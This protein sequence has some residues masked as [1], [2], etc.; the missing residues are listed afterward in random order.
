MPVITLD[1]DRLDRNS[2]SAAHGFAFN[3]TMCD[4]VQWAG[5]GQPCLQ[6]SDGW[7]VNGDVRDLK[8]FGMMVA[9]NASEAPSSVATLA[10]E[11]D[12]AILTPNATSLPGTIASAA[13]TFGTAFTFTTL[14]A[15]ASCTYLNDQCIQNRSPAGAIIITC[16][17]AGWPELPLNTTADDDATSI[18]Q[19]GAGGTSD[20]RIFSVR[21]NSIGYLSSTYDRSIQ[22][23]PNYTWSA[24]PGTIGIQLSMPLTGA[25]K[26][27]NANGQVLADPKGFTFFGC[28]LEYFNVTTSYN[29]I[30]SSY[31]L[32]TATP[33]TPYFA[34]VLLGPLITQLAN[35][36]LLADAQSAILIG[37]NIALNAIVSQDLGRMAIA[38]PSGMFIEVPAAGTSRVD[39]QALGAYP[40]APVI[41]ITILLYLYAVLALSVFLTSRTFTSYNIKVIRTDSDD[42]EQKMAAVALGQKWLTNAIPLVSMAFPEKDG[43][44]GQRSV[45]PRSVEMVDDVDEDRLLLGLYPNAQG[46]TVFGVRNRGIAVEMRENVVSL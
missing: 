18:Y 14:G 2:T 26:S 17:A 37:N 30:S 20:T 39:V 28:S 34:S 41:I 15:R 44:D 38:W 45:A 27:V 19:P 33:S 29:P 36:R 23:F 24:N 32:V 5:P 43:W 21:N 22:Q 11:G 13:S 6:D 10:A 9:Y 46:E 25:L 40:M 16:S 4:A 31:A 35:E 3:Q 1:T 7:A 8:S 12:M 42:R